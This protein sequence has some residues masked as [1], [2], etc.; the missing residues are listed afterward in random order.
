MMSFW[1]NLMLMVFVGLTG[2]G[3]MLPANPEPQAACCPSDD[4]TWVWPLPG[5]H[6]TQRYSATHPG[7]DLSAPVGSTVRAVAPGIVRYAGDSGGPYGKVVIVRHPS[8]CETWS[9]HLNTVD[10]KWQQAISA[11]ERLGQMGGTGN[12]TGWHLH[13]EV[14]SE[15]DQIDPWFCLVKQKSHHHREVVE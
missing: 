7:L 2:P 8:G 1:L 11:G 3:P 9:A 14:R 6:T 13:L 4:L 10:V 5:S 15:V 12:A